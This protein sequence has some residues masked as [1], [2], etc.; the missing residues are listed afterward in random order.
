MAWISLVIVTLLYFAP[1][2]GLARFLL[3]DLS[4][5][6][7]GIPGLGIT[8]TLPVLLIGHLK[9]GLYVLLTWAALWLVLWIVE[10]ATNA[11]LMHTDRLRNGFL[12][13]LNPDFTITLAE[14]LAGGMLLWYLIVL[15]LT[16]LTGVLPLSAV[17]RALLNLLIDGRFIVISFVILIAARAFKWEQRVRYERLLAQNQWEDKQLRARPGR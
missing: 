15:V 13:A 8:L 10:Q 3:D 1:G 16:L 9:L 11:T 14:R 5:I 6:T 4:Q 7:F 12:F 17:L 2:V